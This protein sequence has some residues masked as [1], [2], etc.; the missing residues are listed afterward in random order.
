MARAIQ[1]IAHNLDVYLS[2]RG[3]MINLVDTQT[4]Y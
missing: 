2:G 1:I 4:G 3:E